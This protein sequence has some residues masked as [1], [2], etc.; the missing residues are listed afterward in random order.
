M[1]CPILISIVSCLLLSVF[2][3]DQLD[4]DM[5]GMMFEHIESTNPFE[6][7]FL[8]LSPV[9]G[10]ESIGFAASPRIE[11]NEM[12]DALRQFADMGAAMVTLEKLKKEQKF[13]GGKVFAAFTHNDKG[14]FQMSCGISSSESRD[15]DQVRAGGKLFGNSMMSATFPSFKRANRAERVRAIAACLG[16]LPGM[17]PLKETD[18]VIKGV[19]IDAKSYA[20]GV[21]WF[22]R[23]GWLGSPEQYRLALRCMVADLG[24]KMP[25]AVSDIAVMKTETS[26]DVDL[27]TA[28]PSS[29]G[30]GTMD[31]RERVHS[32]L[33][34]AAVGVMNLKAARV[35]NKG[36]AG[37][38]ACGLWPCKAGFG[39]SALDELF[40]SVAGDVPY[41]A[42][43]VAKLLNASFANGLTEAKGGCK[44]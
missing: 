5:T 42:R 6:A 16:T 33:V 24:R 4:A 39:D 38:D 10:E 21:S 40:K 1:K 20:L 15:W 14:V 28:V 34:V 35:A 30:I 7:F 12:A 29:F 23:H 19:Y 44:L 8:A 43:T 37:L 18:H 25:D 13:S 36:D 2:C 32:E 41:C 9:P 22:Q 26:S 11:G 17:P 31:R 3:A 27:V